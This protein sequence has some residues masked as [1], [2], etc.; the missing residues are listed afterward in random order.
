[1][2]RNVTVYF[3]DGSRHEYQGAP[4]DASPEQI[5]ARAGRDFQGKQIRHL[6]RA[7]AAAAEATPEV[8]RNPFMGAV[9]RG[10]ELLGSGIETLGRAGEA[11]GDVIAEKAPILDTRLMVD[12]EGIRLERRTEEDIRDKNQLQYMQNWADSFR[13]WG[14]E[15]NYEP[16]TKL[17]DLA[18]N[19]LNAVPFIIERVIASSPDMVAA[20]AALPAYI[21][22]RANEIL[23]ERLKNDGRTLSETTIGDVAAA[24]SAA[25]VEGTLE[26]F[27]TRRLVKEGAE[28]ATA[29][30]RIGKEAGVQAGTEA[31]EEVGAYAG[32]TVGTQAGFDPR[33]AGMTALEAAIV[34]GGLGAGVQGARE[35]FGDREQAAPKAPPEEAPDTE[36]DLTPEQL[37]PKT[38]R[39]ARP[40][41]VR[42]KT[43][44]ELRGQLPAAPV[45]PEKARKE[46]APVEP[47]EPMVFERIKEPTPEA[48]QE[49]AEF[50]AQFPEGSKNFNLFKAKS[51]AKKL[52]YENIP[53][54]GV[55]RVDIEPLLR[56]A[57]TPRETIIPAEDKVVGQNAAGEQLYER[58]DGSQYRM[59]LD[60][61]DRPTGY[62]DFGGD[63]APIEASPKI[64][65]P[66]VAAALPATSVDAAIPQFTAPVDFRHTI[67]TSPSYDLE[68]V[69]PEDADFEL[70]V[71]QQQA[72]RGRLTPQNFAQS[73]IGVR[74]DTAQINIINAGLRTDPV[75]TVKSL[76]EKLKPPAAPTETATLSPVTPAETIEAKAA[77]EADP[78]AA[79]V[80][81]AEKVAT[82]SGL[83]FTTAKGSTYAVN[84]DGTTTRS[85]AARPEQPGEEG[86][87]PTSKRTVY[88]DKDGAE[89]LSEIQTQGGARKTLRFDD[90]TNSVAVGYLDGKSAGKVERRT[91]T[92][93]ATDPAI[94]L[95]PVEYWG[96]NKTVHFGNEI[97]K[98]TPPEAP[99][100]PVSTR[101]GEAV[102]GAT[103][104]SP[105]LP[106]Q[107]GVPAGREATESRV[108][109][110]EPARGVAER[111][112]EREEDVSSALTEEATQVLEAAQERP[113]HTLSESEQELVHNRLSET[114]KR[115][116]A[117]EFGQDS[118]NDVAKRGFLE[119][120]IKGA[121][122]GIKAVRARLRGIVR[123][124]IVALLSTGAVFNASAFTNLAPKP[125]LV[126]S[127]S[128]FRTAETV[129]PVPPAEAAEAMSPAARAVYERFM[130][131]NTG[132]PFIIA[133]KP[134]GQVF[135]FKANGELIEFAPALFGKA[136]GDVLP[137]LVGQKL[138]A[139]EINATLDSEK[140]TP[141]GEFTAVLRR[142]RDFPLQL[143]FQDAQ[144][145]VG[146]MAIHQVYTGNIKERRLERLAS[147]DVT[148]NKVSYGCINVGVDT[149]NN[150][151]VP[152]YSKG[153]RVGV[154]PDETGALDKF[155]PPPEV[156][157]RYTVSEAGESKTEVV[158]V[159]KA[160]PI[161]APEPFGL[162]RKPQQKQDRR[163]VA[164]RVDERDDD[165][166]PALEPRQ[167]QLFLNI[168]KL[169][170]NAPVLSE[171]AGERTPS[172]R[173]ELKKAKKDYDAG[174]LT[175]DQLA[176]TTG[177][178]LL[179]TQKERI[180]QL[181][182][183]GADYIRERLMN[184]RR[185][186]FIS[187]EGID[188]A[189]W[190]IRQNPLLVE[191]LGISI[192]NRPEEM[193]GTAGFYNP[194]SR[195][196][197]LFKGVV[198][199][200]T[201]T[202]EILHHLER[203]MPA[204]IRSGILKAY[205][206]Q[207]TKAEKNAKTDAEKQFF[208]A[209][210]NYHY[211][212]T[213][214]NRNAEYEKALDA[215]KNRK[216][217]SSFYQY[218][219]PSEFWA[220]NGSRIVQGRY[221]MSPGV[222]GQIR[223]W[224]RD[225][226][227]KAKDIFGLKSDAAIIRALD[228]LAKADGKYQTDQ[229]LVEVPGYWS[230]EP[231]K[232]G[233]PKKPKP[234]K[235]KK[236]LDE[237]RREASVK[238]MKPGVIRQVINKLT[239]PETSYETIAKNFQSVSRKVKKLQEDL[240]IAGKLISVGDD[241]NNIEDQTSIAAN[242]A[243]YIVA[244]EVEPVA[245]RL[246]ESLA[247]YA[248]V[249][250]GTIK[251]ALE[252][253]DG[254][255]IALHEPER[256][257]TKYLRNVPLNNTTKMEF[258]PGE[259]AMTAADARTKLEERRSLADTPQKQEAVLDMMRYLAANHADPLGYSPVK[260]QLEA[261][262]KEVPLEMTTDFYD[263]IYNVIGTEYTQE[264]LDATRE[265]YEG[266]DAETK[267]AVD[268]VFADF[269]ALN[270][271]NKNLNRRA[272]YWT[273][274]VDN[275]IGTY[276]W[277]HYAPFKGNPR[278]D[279]TL[280][281][282]TE[283]LSGELS[284][285]PESF[286]GRRTEFDSPI[287]QSIAESYFAAS[288]AGRGTD[289]TQTIKNLIKLNIIKSA[290]PKV[291]EFEERN[292]PNFDYSQVQGRDKVLHYN[293]DG[294]V[295]VFSIKDPDML[296]AI[297]V[298]YREMNLVVKIGNNLTSLFGQLHTRY[299]PAF[300]PMDL[301]RNT[302][303][304]AGLISAREGGKEAREYLIA[305]AANV[306]RLRMYKA[307]RLSNLLAKNNIAKLDEL[308]KTDSFYRDALEM[309]EYGGVTFYRMSVNISN[310]MEDL[311]KQVGPK[312]I[313]TQPNMLARWI[314]AYNDGF[315][316]TSR[317]SAYTLR[318]Q[319][320]IAE[321]KKKGLN[322][323]DPKVMEDINKEAAAFSLSLMDFRK[324]GKYGREMSAWFMFIRPAA[325]GAV[326]AI[327]ALR[328]GF[329]LKPKS[330][331]E[332]GFARLE[333]EIQELFETQGLAEEIK[334]IQN[335]KRPDK[336]KI[337]ALEQE[338]VDREKA[339]DA[340]EKR[341]LTRAKNARNTAMFTI[342]TGAALYAMAVMASGDD[343]EGRNRVL[344]DDMS[345]WTR[346]LRLPV[347]GDKGFFQ[348]PWGFGVSSLASA[349]AQVAAAANGQL[350][351][352][353]FA[354]NMVEIGMD[355]FLPIPTSRIS[356]FES[357]ENFG[358][359]LLD[360]A[361]PSVARPLVE[362]VLNVDAMGN[363][364]YNSRSGKYA[365]AFSGSTRPSE[366][367][368]KISELIFNT[369][370]GEVSLS[371]DSI[372]F[373]L[374][375]YADG[376]NHLAE[377]SFNLVLTSMGDKNF[378]AKKDTFLL[379]S[380]IGRNSN[381]DAR[382]Y[383]EAE[384]GI[385]KLSQRLKTFEDLG[386][387]EQVNKFYRENPNADILVDTYNKGSGQ[388]SKLQTERK[389]ILLDR[390]L[391]PKQ[392]EDFVQDVQVEM[393]YLKMLLVE[394]FKAYSGN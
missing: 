371:P 180:V 353:D 339:F 97:T 166:S 278:A 321:A 382:E 119:E 132:V 124:V 27:A 238:M 174:V 280:D 18:D 72:E 202:H 32:E 252:K 169:N 354:G 365:D 217:P 44:D 199:S 214:A 99:S 96:D 15:I 143:N 187:Q 303:T 192:R 39:A 176:E 92:K 189:E 333:P 208:S 243:A 273:D 12:R 223:K 137:H 112:D 263:D 355:S 159:K 73:E 314:D 253:A 35:V 373:F 283:Y 59:R 138:T 224:L 40:S 93:F 279:K 134:S 135:L 227:E 63:L 336:K 34:G 58:Q 305:V 345:R 298:P 236:S 372:A 50:V 390:S 149:W 376:V 183:R 88:V 77:V 129:R 62:P 29:T 203:L 232:T 219:N 148:D 103:A 195:I 193:K 351:F 394:D 363:P 1:M 108:S 24:T 84:D 254:Y 293:E 387:L 291:F 213:E 3:A 68:A 377:N 98:V 388:L 89:R 184:A 284:E 116:I 374:N 341:Q 313:L 13:N 31:V 301:I 358:A 83:T 131:N 157:V 386:T 20:A 362:F 393:N 140:I 51:I 154:V 269:D 384:K 55:G 147:A 144:G 198:D 117:Q 215:I 338:I 37:A 17:G 244:T 36:E 106:I 10:A 43:L 367:H 247:S 264:E 265:E 113:T 67:L 128:T 326:D 168:A 245:K 9:A 359:W 126:A 352:R 385:K 240:R 57:V 309:R 325:T 211:F 257:E 136:K 86:L 179:K 114:Q 152:N 375:N 182:K 48:L 11:I 282:D 173:V 2:P 107:R 110:V 218:V 78:A 268:Q 276:G 318:K 82:P 340:F 391:T 38:G 142:G 328:P 156:T 259:P 145:N 241:K 250:K 235:P 65:P 378:D 315:E 165:V 330:A 188:L 342:A 102:A 266:L 121:N 151:I 361:A 299:N 79:P 139:E 28:A 133:D 379:R 160:E 344:T 150:Y 216:V 87:Q 233:K 251:D 94:G 8:T 71:L 95:T 270:E 41:P 5:A 302:I 329:F 307:G 380:F 226:L 118:Y 104:G 33:T 274:K 167:Q 191:N 368:R 392:R 181:R 196:I 200:Q 153:A 46:K 383:A 256:R 186:N 277:K 292:A 115:V 271:L 201:A 331:V 54:K 158:S 220:V 204:N 60:R 300:A 49:A 348:V 234:T 332:K 249:M 334:R 14:R 311:K 322:I 289:V 172:L 294:S 111:V 347:I 190:F 162:P 21:P 80:A 52:G 297:K 210:T 260:A 161:S 61:A 343:D 22:T 69:S 16:S 275:V 295:E 239:S 6:E 130:L 261:K 185:N 141:A 90:A 163:G 146:V 123:A 296:E 281:T 91:V 267:A 170:E 155:I 308:A 327:D 56:M 366:I 304:N 369:T 350:S 272:N 310:T 4:D 317:V 346:Y 81:P 357:A 30:R 19:P 335:N 258:L 209:I 42:A 109:G 101:A 370:D 320:N 337:A 194:I 105:A 171:Q 255:R 324:V 175:G 164:R 248:R 229:M 360:S 228:S 389:E 356:P 205:V 120:V 7:P 237:L 364:I 53:Q 197:T 75:G 246:R 230:V 262:G 70:E 26:R 316:L 23:N 74:L 285:A 221:D 64:T 127:G 323:D 122:Q 319:N 349:G 306:A 225:F 66:P 125:M 222:V 206:K 231:I 288:R 290:R 76:R 177:D 25:V 85:K 381:Y 212:S 286:E 178:L 312:K 45:V 242:R 207:L 47:R 287:L 100:E